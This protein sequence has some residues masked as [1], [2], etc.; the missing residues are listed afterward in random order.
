VHKRSPP[1]LIVAADSMSLG[2]HR[3][4]SS[5]QDEVFRL[6]DI[7][8][9]TGVVI[10]VESSARVF[11]HAFVRE[12]QDRGFSVFLDLKL[13]GTMKTLLTD[14]K[15]LAD[16]RPDFLTIDI[17]SGVSA[18]RTVKSWL[19][20]TKVL[21]IPVLTT[22][23][24]SDTEAIFGCTTKCAVERLSKLALGDGTLDGVIAAP[25]ELHLLREALPEAALL[26]TPNIR[27]PHIQVKGDDQN[28]ERSMTVKEAIQAGA[29]GVVVGRIITGALKPYDVT[30]WLRE[31]IDSAVH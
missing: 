8:E 21:G 19:R 13:K 25:L 16:L 4:P 28:P 30:M 12:I 3:K 20:H 5:L 9:G 18:M 1:S 31:E 2:F 11:G 14:A 29:D 17:T 7:L 23:Y 15:L 10:K 26:I 6:C 27:Y 24:E 22:H